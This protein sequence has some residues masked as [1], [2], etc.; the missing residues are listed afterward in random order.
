MRQRWNDVGERERTSRL[1]RGD[2]GEVF[3][4]GFPPRL[5]LVSSFPSG[6]AERVES[7]FD[8]CVRDELPAEILFTIGYKGVETV[9][10]T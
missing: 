4:L 6:V 5:K 7:I 1:R 10:H 9:R 3:A 8:I 2:G